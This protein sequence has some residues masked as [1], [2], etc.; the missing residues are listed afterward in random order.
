MRYNQNEYYRPSFF[1]GFSFFPPVIK[2]LLITNV[3]VFLLQL[4]LSNTVVQGL[5]F[6]FLLKKYFALNPLTPIRFTDGYEI[7]EFKFHIWQLVTYMFLH[8]DFMHIFFNMFALWMFG[9]ELEH[10]FGSK[11]F[12]WYYMACGIGGGITNLLLS[13]LFSHPAPTIGASGAVFGILLAFGLM[14]PDRLIF[15]YFL[16]PIKAKYFVIIYL[17]LEILAVGSSDMVAHLAHLGGALTGYIFILVDEKRLPFQWLFDS[18]AR[19]RRRSREAFFNPKVNNQV[20][21]ADYYNIETGK[22]IN[23]DSDR[24]TQ[25]NIDIILDK[26]SKSGYQSL[27]EEEKHILFEASKKLD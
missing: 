24:I 16:I 19:N 9:M 8:A 4:L 11:K 13:P 6:E 1:G 10:V 21:D 3:A 27:T 14:F 20:Q 7:F 26:I 22:K 5:P 23:K 18:A 12:F 25:E 17:V 15:F 2:M